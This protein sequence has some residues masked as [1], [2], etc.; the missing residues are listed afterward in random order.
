VGVMDYAVVREGEHSSNSKGRVEI[1]VL[2]SARARDVIGLA[3]MLL[4]VLSG[5]NNG[6]CLDELITKYPWLEE[7]RGC[8]VLAFNQEYTFKA[9]PVK[10]MDE[11]PIIPA[12]SG[13]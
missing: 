10:D 1:V 12:I 13:G 8:M 5:S 4:E 11:L 9:A 2:F 7:I 3:K 6:D